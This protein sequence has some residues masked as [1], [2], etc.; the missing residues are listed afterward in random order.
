M[1]KVLFK[2]EQRFNQ[3]WL[4]LIVLAAFLI[5]AVIIIVEIVQQSDTED[6]NSYIIAL[7]VIMVLGFIVLGLIRSMKLVVEVVE[8]EIRF[9][10]RPV[11]NKWKRINKNEIKSYEVRKYKPIKE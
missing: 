6:F 8:N 3:W 7:S 10:Y 5:P 1:E 9:K 2:E 11:I 4:W